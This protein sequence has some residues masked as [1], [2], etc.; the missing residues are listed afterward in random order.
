M[1][2]SAAALLLAPGP[3]DAGAVRFGSVPI[4]PFAATRCSPTGSGVSTACFLVSVVGCIV[5]G[6]RTA[7]G[8]R[9]R[10]LKQ[11]LTDGDAAEDNPVQHVMINVISYMDLVN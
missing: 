10:R 9:R 3:T 11:R 5:H 1:G 8:E 7:C 2:T 4:E 6:L